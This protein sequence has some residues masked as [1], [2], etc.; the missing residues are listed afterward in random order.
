MPH[1]FGTSDSIA[2]AMR[3]RHCSTRDTESDVFGRVGCALVGRR[4]VQRVL[5][6]NELVFEF[7]QHLGAGC[8]IDH[9]ISPNSNLPKTRATNSRVAS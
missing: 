9:T 4:H 7:A 3:D 6:G 5:I 2:A 8:G 1:A